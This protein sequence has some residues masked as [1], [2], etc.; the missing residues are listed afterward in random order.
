MRLI[1]PDL[2]SQVILSENSPAVIT[3]EAPD[4]FYRLVRQIYAQAQARDDEGDFSLSENYK[5]LNISKEIEVTL[6]PILIDF[7][8]RKIIN[9]IFSDFDRL[10]AEPEHLEATAELHTSVEKYL[11]RLAVDYPVPVIW[12]DDFVVSNIVKSMDLAIDVHEMELVSR[13]LTYMQLLTSLR[14]A[15]IF[16]FVNLKSYLTTEQLIELYHESR[17]KKYTLLLLESR[18]APHVEDYE[19]CLTLDADLC[20]VV[21]DFNEIE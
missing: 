7:G 1:H 4:I 13:I 6:N 12:S 5:E 8:Q 9:R 20:V 10:A 16:T 3:V 17:L 2:Q 11:A 21:N 15:R 19:K 14:L 18:S